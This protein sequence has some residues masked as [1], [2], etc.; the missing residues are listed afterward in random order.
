LQSYFLVKYLPMEIFLPLISDGEDKSCPLKNR[1]R[2]NY[3]H[4]RKWA[5]RTHTN[6]FRIYDKDIKEYPFAIDFYAGRFLIHYFTDS[7][8]KEPREDLFSASMD[9]IQS[10]FS[11]SEEK[12]YLKSRIKRGKKEQYEK[13]ADCKEFFSILEHGVQF[14]VNLLDYLDTGLF[15]DHRQTRQIVAKEAKGKRLL[16]LFSYTCSFSVQAAMNGASFTKS[17]DLSNTY[18]EW[19]KKNFLLNQI[20]LKNHSI[21]R[22]D[23]LKFLEEEVAKRSR[24]DVIVIDPPT[25]S[26]SKKMEKFFD[27]QE[28]YLNLISPCLTLLAKEGSIFFSTNSRKFSFDTAKLPQAVVEDIAQKTL[29]LDFHNAKTH[30][31]WKISHKEQNNLN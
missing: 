20:P 11:V 9:A 26:R 5:K 24:Y 27:L 10:L 2:K 8:D 17:V 28:E 31:C 22:E 23:C 16:N 21:I 19:G 7:L 3:K 13:V 12:I 18:T 30:Q 4:L 25:I 29:P 6:A 1:I 15:L 14:N